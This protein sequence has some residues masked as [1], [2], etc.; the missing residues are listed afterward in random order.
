MIKRN[1]DTIICRKHNKECDVDG[2]YPKFFAFCEYCNDYADFDMIEYG[3]NWIT[4]KHEGIILQA[5]SMNGE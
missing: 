3:V 4:N 1:C 2:D 5:E